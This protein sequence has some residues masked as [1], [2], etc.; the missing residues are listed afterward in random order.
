VHHDHLSDPSANYWV[1]D[2]IKRA[3][4]LALDDRDPM[5]A[6]DVH[7][8][9]HGMCHIGSVRRHLAR[10]AADG[11]VEQTI[12]GWVR[13]LEAVE[14]P[15]IDYQRARRDRHEA[16]RASWRQWRAD[17]NKGKDGRS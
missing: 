5:T 15:G 3:V 2:G 14:P 8:A 10:L 4:W 17:T 1:R 7:E 9:V 6:V 11:L 16:E 12:D 13:R